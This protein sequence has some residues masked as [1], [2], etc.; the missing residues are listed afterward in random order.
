MLR[1]ES[2]AVV[3]SYD[4]IA[5]AAKKKVP[6][7][8]EEL[9]L[10]VLAKCEEEFLAKVGDQRQLDA[11]RCFGSSRHATAEVVALTREVASAFA[12]LR[13]AARNAMRTVEKAE[14]VV[15]DSEE[16]FFRFASRTEYENLKWLLD[17]IK[18][19]PG[20][21]D[22]PFIQTLASEKPY[23]R[24]E[25][26]RLLTWLEAS[27]VFG[28]RTPHRIA[29]VLSNRQ[30]AIV[31]LLSGNYP[32]VRRGDSVADVIGTERRLIAEARRHY[33]TRPRWTPKE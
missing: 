8:L 11:V 7:S 21:D 29:K 6:N 33:G 19:L 27:V 32:P 9:K 30:A 16:A 3:V 31:S 18:V 17:G 1:S 28:K 15:H 22:T 24:S 25:R 14:R 26:T 2:R 20:Y 4:A 13:S 23:A 12:A 10:L 5:M